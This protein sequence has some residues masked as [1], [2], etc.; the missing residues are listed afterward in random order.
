[1][2]AYEPF[3]CLR[4]HPNRIVGARIVAASKVDMPLV[5]KVLLATFAVSP[6]GLP[7]EPAQP[8]ALASGRYS[9]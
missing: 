7:I 2:I 3:Y 9:V 1:M 5:D 4:C 8:Q 6:P